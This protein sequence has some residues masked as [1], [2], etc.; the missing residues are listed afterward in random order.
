MDAQFLSL[1]SSAS[2]PISS[3]H[4]FTICYLNVYINA[5]RL[6]ADSHPIVFSWIQQRP[7]SQKM[8]DGRQKCNSL[9]PRYNTYLGRIKTTTELLQYRFA[10]FVAAFPIPDHDHRTPVLNRR[11]LHSVDHQMFPTFPSHQLQLDAVGWHDQS[12]ECP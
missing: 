9:D 5:H 11:R 4:V 6:T 10:V 12:A 1:S 3:V 2:K 8:G 7:F